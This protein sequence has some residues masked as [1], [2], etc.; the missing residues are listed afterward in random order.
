MKKTRWHTGKP[1]PAAKPSTE[2]TISGRVYELMPFLKE[3]ESSIKG[4]VMV[5][6][7]KKFKAN[8][9]KKDGQFILKHQTE[10]PSEY[11]GK[12]YLVL[13]AWRRP[14]FP[15]GVAYLRWR[16]YRW[17]Q[18][19]NWLDSGWGGHARLLRRVK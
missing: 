1:L 19:W 4:D 7:A 11:Q 5:R 17:C 2:F 14:S 13:T 6:R 8:L 10:I 15:R 16:G 9:G 18:N 3:G 12:F